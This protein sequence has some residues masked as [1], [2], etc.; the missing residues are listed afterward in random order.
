MRN[1]GDLDIGM[2]RRVAGKLI[3]RSQME[4]IPLLRR[5]PFRQAFW[6]VVLFFEMKMRNIVDLDI[7]EMTQT[8]AGK[9]FCIS[10][11]ESIPLLRRA[12]FRQAFWREFFLFFEMKM[13]N[14]GDLDIGMTRR[15]A[16]KLIRRSL[17][18]SI[19][20][21]RRASSRQA[22]LVGGA[23]YFFAC[24]RTPHAQMAKAACLIAAAP[25]N[26]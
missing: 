15:V 2:T 5:A 8:G 17:M 20:L 25:S 4:S 26:R 3:R 16:G 19:P 23:V 11:M 10:Q 1:I 13:R 22:C 24:R 18:E 21:L 12:P 7:V 14:I 9:L 6:R